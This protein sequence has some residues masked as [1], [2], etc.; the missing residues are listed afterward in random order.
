M[1]IFCK[2]KDENGEKCLIQSWAYPHALSTVY[3]CLV[4]GIVDADG[5]RY[6]EFDDGIFVRSLPNGDLQVEEK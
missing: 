4:H 3:R 2:V 1:F 6:D 5:N